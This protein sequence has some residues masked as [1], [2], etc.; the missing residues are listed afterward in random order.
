[1]P[2]R[3]AKDTSSV[4]GIKVKHSTSKLSKDPCV[5]KVDIEITKLLCDNDQGRSGQQ[6]T[7]ISSI[8][9]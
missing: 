9:W 7:F 3:L 1:M 8:F 5:G 2:G 6:A 4:L